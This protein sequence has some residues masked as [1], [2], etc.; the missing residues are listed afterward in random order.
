M[1]CVESACLIYT[2]EDVGS[3]L[4]WLSCI[5]ANTNHSRH[6]VQLS[7]FSAKPDEG[8][9]ALFT[10]GTKLRTRTIRAI[11]GF[12]AEQLDCEIWR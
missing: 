7:P 10:T 6:P 5:V 4:P 1:L 8:E 2:T 12:T 3:W 9:V 11:H